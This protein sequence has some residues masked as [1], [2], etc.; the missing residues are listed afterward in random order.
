MIGEISK[1]HDCP[2]CELGELRRLSRVGFV[3]REL[4]HSFGIY[5]WECVL[6]RKKSY[7]RDDGHKEIARRKLSQ[8]KSV[9]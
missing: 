9:A 4:L 3:E 8:Q 7:L 5:P 2:K 1:K 6:C